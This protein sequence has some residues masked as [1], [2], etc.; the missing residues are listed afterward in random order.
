MSH[1]RARMQRLRSLAGL[2]ISLQTDTGK[3]LMRPKG[4]KM[5]THGVFIPRGNISAT[6][7]LSPLDWSPYR[8]GR[9]GCRPPCCTLSMHEHGH[10]IVK[11]HRSPRA[12]AGALCSGSTEDR[13]AVRAATRW[14]TFEICCT[15]DSN[16]IF[17]LIRRGSFFFAMLLHCPGCKWTRH[18]S[19]CPAHWWGGTE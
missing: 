2:Q 14:Q 6:V 5:W 13:E 8:L 9:T 4:K 10:K 18:P 1:Q 11:T 16:E 19:M 17:L 3:W 12:D 7:Q 15:G